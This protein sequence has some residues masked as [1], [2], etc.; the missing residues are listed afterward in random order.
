MENI[1]VGNTIEVKNKAGLEDLEGVF[2]KV[3]TIYAANGTETNTAPFSKETNVH[4]DFSNGH[5]Q[6]F[7][8]ED[9]VLTTPETAEPL[10]TM[11]ATVTIEY[12]DGSL[13]ER[14]HYGNNLKEVLEAFLEQNKENTFEV[15]DKIT[16]H[17]TKA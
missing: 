12:N 3:T 15:D 5:S 10:G 11:E 7:N 14:E 16:F 13:E 4:I 1:H 6:F 9:L 8:C 2:G 17:L